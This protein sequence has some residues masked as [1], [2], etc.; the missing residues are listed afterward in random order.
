MLSGPRIIPIC[1]DLRSSA[2]VVFLCLLRLFRLRQAHGA[3]G[4]T[5]IRIRLLFAALREIFSVFVTFVIF[6]YCA[7]RIG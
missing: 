6:P 4:F 5:A 7:N 2:V 3:T 1:V